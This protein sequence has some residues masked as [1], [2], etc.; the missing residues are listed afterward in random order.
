MAAAPLGHGPAQP[1]IEMNSDH[2]STAIW[3]FGASPRPHGDVS[4]V[5]TRRHVEVVSRRS[6]SVF[7]VDA[8]GFGPT[9]HDA[10]QR[11]DADPA[12]L[13][14]DICGLRSC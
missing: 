10:P 14:V 4:D 8:P 9:R 11:S 2:P 12:G 3:W 13:P 6:Q 1:L 7:T 5:M